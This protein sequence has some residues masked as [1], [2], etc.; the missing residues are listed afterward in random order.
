MLFWQNYH[1]HILRMYF[2]Y[3]FSYIIL[4]IVDLRSMKRLKLL[5]I[6]YDESKIAKKLFLDEYLDIYNDLMY[7]II[8]NM[9]SIDFTVINSLLIHLKLDFY[10]IHLYLGKEIIKLLYLKSS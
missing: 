5:L 3:Y 7:L 10:H 1:N 8:C 2:K 4:N 9:K 6:L